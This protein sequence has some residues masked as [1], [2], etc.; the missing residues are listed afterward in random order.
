MAGLVLAHRHV[1]GLVDQDVGRLQQRV[2][3]ESVGGQIL[4]FE[5][6]LLVLVGGYT[7]EPA[8]GCAHGQQREQLGM[9][10]QSALQEDGALLGIQARGQPVDHH[11]VDVFLDD[12]A[13][14]VVGGQGM[15]VG[16]EV[17]ALHL[18]LQAN[19]VLEGSV[20]VTQVQG[21]G[22]AHARENTIFHC[23]ISPKIPAG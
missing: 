7:L 20:V 18:G 19:P 4:V 11:L 2:A 17:K 14:F 6:F 21:P 3:Q 1:L 10:G 16:H 5:L 9:F 15:P 8:Q 22:G 23:V 12:F 13:A